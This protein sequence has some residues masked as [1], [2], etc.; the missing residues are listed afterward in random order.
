MSN[1]SFIQWRVCRALAF[2]TLLGSIVGE[3]E[4][5]WQNNDVCSGGANQELCFDLGC[6]WDGSLGCAISNCKKSLQIHHKYS[7]RFF[8]SLLFFNLSF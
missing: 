6:C 3:C 5:A 2:F 4:G 8:K 1:L 7:K